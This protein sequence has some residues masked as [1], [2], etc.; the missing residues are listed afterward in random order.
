MTRLKLTSFLTLKRE[1]LILAFLEEDF[2]E[3]GLLKKGAPRLTAEKRV[4]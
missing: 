4:E 2:C 3:S 1:I